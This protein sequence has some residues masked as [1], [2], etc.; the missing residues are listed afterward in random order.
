MVVRNVCLPVD[1]QHRAVSVND[2]N[3][4]V[5]GSAGFFVEA[6]GEDYLQFRSDFPQLCNGRIFRRRSCQFIG[7]VSPFLTE[8]RGF[9]QFRQQN[10][11]CSVSGCLPYHRFGSAAVFGGIGRA[12]HL[13]GCNSDFTHK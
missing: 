5:Q 2:R 3:G 9:E 12:C 10:D 4:I 8:V 11:L 6:D 13:N 7:G 1:A